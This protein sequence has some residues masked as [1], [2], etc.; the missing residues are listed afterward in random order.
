MLW[1]FL[2]WKT[3]PYGQKTLL[4]ESEKKYFPNISPHFWILQATKYLIY[5]F[6]L[7]FSFFFIWSKLNW[8]LFHLSGIFGCKR[9]KD[10][11]EIS[12]WNIWM[13]RKFMISHFLIAF[14]DPQPSSFALQVV[15]TKSSTTLFRHLLT[16]SFTLSLNWLNW[17]LDV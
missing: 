6:T 14:E 12:V 7:T 5:D 2:V 16:H 3:P 10:K 4:S 11:V 1:Y 17:P 9:M 15:K 13:W 8:A